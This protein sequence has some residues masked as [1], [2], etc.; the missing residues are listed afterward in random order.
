VRSGGAAARGDGALERGRASHEDLAVALAESL[1]QS[2]SGTHLAIA[3]ASRRATDIGLVGMAGLLELP[4]AELPTAELPKPPSGAASPSSLTK[5]TR[6]DDVWEQGEEGE[7]AEAAAAAAAAAASSHWSSSVASRSARNAA[8]YNGV[9][10]A[11]AAAAVG[12]VGWVQRGVTAGGV[13]LEGISAGRVTAEGVFSKEVSAGGVDR[14]E[15]AIVGEGALKYLPVVV[16]AEGDR[17]GAF[18]AASAAA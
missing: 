16:T 2:R 13:C 11:S 14:S 17:S 15:V 7:A 3:S 12:G 1:W 10:A 4:T 5:E 6:R 8:E 9:G 18:T